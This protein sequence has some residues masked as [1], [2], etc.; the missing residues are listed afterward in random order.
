MATELKRNENG[1]YILD[2][3]TKTYFD[4]IKESIGYVGTNYGW[5]GIKEL[6]QK[7]SKLENANLK[8]C[9]TYDGYANSSDISIYQYKIDDK[10]RYCAQL[11]Y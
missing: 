5:D 8:L 6:L 4:R 3:R 1:F 9:E 2:E 7:S 10:T 11:S